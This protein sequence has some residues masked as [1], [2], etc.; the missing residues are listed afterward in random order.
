MSTPSLTIVDNRSSGHHSTYINKIAEVLIAQKVDF[1]ILYPNPSELDAHLVETGRIKKLNLYWAKKCEKSLRFKTISLWLDIIMNCRKISVNGKQTKV[2][3]AW[4]DD[5]TFGQDHPNILK[6]WFYIIKFWGPKSWSGIYFHPTHLREKNINGFFKDLVFSLPNCKEV[7]VLDSGVVSP[8]AEKLKKNV[9]TFPDIT[10]V[11]YTETSNTLQQEIKLRSKKRKIVALLGVI[12]KR[13]GI[14]Q[15][16]RI[17]QSLKEFFFLFAG[18]LDP[19]SFTIEELEEINIYSNSNHENCFFYFSSVPDGS[20]FNGLVSLSD[21]IYAAYLNFP[22]SSNLLVKAAYF[23][24]PVIVSKGYFMEEIA[25]QYKF[26]LSVNPEDLNEIKQAIFTLQN[27][28]VDINLQQ[29]Y[30][31]KNAD[32]ELKNTINKILN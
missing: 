24:K 17:S 20:E 8:L 11:S 4:A 29:A 12:A 28:T 30:Y 2:L 18:P 10:D 31:L 9:Y 21:I 15:L 1:K 5:L 22:H 27:F 19:N 26:G 6:L 23:N 25:N 7:L 13:K 16:L 3:F 14:I 32:G